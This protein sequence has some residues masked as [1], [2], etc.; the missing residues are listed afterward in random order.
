MAKEK[1][2]QNKSGKNEP[3]HDAGEPPVHAEQTLL[4]RNSVCT[5]RVGYRS[6]L[7]ENRFGGFW[8]CKAFWAAPG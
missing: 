7:D 4:L 2:E 5:V 1:G 8:A 3:G 6:D